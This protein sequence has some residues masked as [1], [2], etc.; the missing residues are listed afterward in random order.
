VITVSELGSFVLRFAVEVDESAI[1][2]IEG[3][4][5]AGDIEEDGIDAAP[6]GGNAICGITEVGDDDI[7]AFVLK[8]VGGDGVVTGLDEG[9]GPPG[10]LS[11]TKGDWIGGLLSGGDVACGIDVT[12]NGKACAAPSGREGAGR[13][14]NSSS[15]RFLDRLPGCELGICVET[16]GTV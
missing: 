13:V 4:N 11:S 15:V 9:T 8:I 7:G 2:P 3:S 10:R 1:G 16:G 5:C 6:A 12:G 14:S